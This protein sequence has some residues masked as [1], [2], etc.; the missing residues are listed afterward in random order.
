MASN[1]PKF[2]SFRP[3][4]KA[5]AAAAAAAAEPPKDSRK[6]EKR[7]RS[8]TRGT[9]SE[10]KRPSLPEPQDRDRAFPPDKPYFSDRRGD[11]D[12][13]RY[14]N[15]NQ[16]D[17]PTF[18][19]YGN[20][21]VLGLSPSQRIA[22][23]YTTAKNM[24]ITPVLPQRQDR[25]LTDKQYNKSTN[26]ALKL[27]KIGGEPVDLSLDFVPLTSTSG[28]QRNG[29][30]DEDDQAA[31]TSYRNITGKA[32]SREPADPDTYYES[33]ALIS[34][35]AETTR[36]NAKLIRRTRDQPEDLDG[37]LAL[38][39]HQ[40]AM[41]KLDQPSAD[42][43]AS[44]RAHLAELRIS[45]YE[46]ALK[47]IGSDHN[48]LAK[49]YQ[50][51]LHEAQEIWDEKK[52]STKWNE[53]LVKYADSVEL[54]F[55]YL[56]FVQSA[57]AAFKYEH[58]RS[59]FLRCLESLHKNTETTPAAVLHVVLRL[60]S[61]MSDAG[62]QE[63]ALAIWQALLE[64]HMMRPETGPAT[65]AFERFWES[66]LPRIGEVGAKG[67][68]HCT[69]DAVPPPDPPALLVPDPSADTFENFW[70]CEMDAV[71]KLKY[72]GRTSHEVG[73]DDAFH[74]VFFSDIEHVLRFVPASVPGLL[75]L[76]AFLCFSGLPPVPRSSK[77]GQSWWSDPILHRQSQ[78]DA[79]TE[80]KSS[81][82]TIGMYARCL[83]Q[84]FRMTSQLLFEQSFSTDGATGTAFIRRLLT[85]LAS[86]PTF[87]E[88]IGE[89]LL[90][91]ELQHFPADVHKTAKRLLKARPASQRLYNAYGLVESY[92]G[93]ST[94]S[95]Q[96]FKSALSIRQ[97]DGGRI[98]PNALEILHNWVWEALCRGDQ[99]EA[100][101]RL[102]SPLGIT[103]G[104]N[105]PQT[106][107]STELVNCARTLLSETCA[108]SLVHEDYPSAIT[109]TSLSALLTYL[110]GDYDA[111]SALV[112]QEHLSMW[113]T[114]H[115]LS[116]S[117]FAELQAQAI[118]RLLTHYM[119]H[120]P[121]VRPVLIRE[122]LEPL[123]V[124]F[125]SN[126]ML[127]ALYAV[128]EA[129]FSVDDRVRGIMHRG[130]LHSSSRTTV[131]G[132][133]FAIH[134]ETLRGEI[135]GSTSHSIRAIFKHATEL[136]GA[137]CPTLWKSYVLFELMQLHQIISIYSTK[138]LRK[139]GKKE[140]GWETRIEEA[141]H[142]MK[143]TFY[144]GLR[145][146][147]WCKNYIMLAFVEACE[148]FNDKEKWKLYRIM[149]EK[150]MRLY[151]DLDELLD[152]VTLA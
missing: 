149:Q 82:L 146:L 44:G 105:E 23:E 60:T 52:L 108:H 110:F 121:I 49:L 6:V 20:G 151:T 70:N 4:Q 86:E 102:V 79:W 68:K 119:T 144:L 111:K 117:P 103:T 152:N 126:T 125:P 42:L 72:P 142:R 30:S 141:R 80:R 39:D 46:E 21:C 55:S 112:V 5:A 109:S 37:W 67:W 10:E 84:N 28:S 87:A 74:T 100:F 143:E 78:S 76:D 3:K 140:P 135:A 66:E 24:Y 50:G 51:L 59:I 47:K 18:R 133:A 48:K 107:P 122:T 31:A 83:V 124:K 40:E 91:F 64:L 36:T 150:E 11:P 97:A 35:D 106:P 129:R 14:G 101:W 93:N 7:E 81:G 62:Y 96:V 2:T 54:W 85:L 77:H 71:T 43:S 104:R 8:A 120:A 138:V 134:V 41:L 69:S 57:F 32:S 113:F 127:L 56:D 73:E 137:H 58:C 1:I 114:S 94:K 12:V 88:D 17:I 29:T 148:V 89:Y 22:R 139:G 53:V 9:R 90:A 38:V 131:P 115:K 130:S 34:V 128:N 63:L 16:Y 95:D 19:R 25:L 136:V 61:M 15:L 98:T 65:D 26:H 132:W 27:V 92:R 13:L 45:I 145:N 33:E 123:L 99:M 147:P 118:I 75:V 116:A